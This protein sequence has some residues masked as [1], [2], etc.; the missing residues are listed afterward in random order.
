M[1][2]NEKSVEWVIPG[3]L[4]RILYRDVQWQEEYGA[5]GWER[6]AATIETA[7]VVSS[8]L[9]DGRHAPV[10]DIDFQ[11]YLIPSST[12]GH[13]HLYL[14]KPMTWRKYKRMLRALA[15]AGVIEKGYAKASISRRH[16]AVRVPWLKKGSS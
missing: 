12:H 7:E 6:K 9:I 13:Y 3:E 2:K 5:G 15:S 8:K 14:D 4:D 10:L 1:G 11:A 16:T